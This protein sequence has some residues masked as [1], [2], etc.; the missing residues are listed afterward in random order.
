MRLKICKLGPIKTNCYIIMNEATGEAVI[1]DPA[2]EPPVDGFVPVAVLLTHGHFD[3][4]T[5]VNCLREKHGAKI[6]TSAIERELLADPELNGSTMF[7]RP[8]SEFAN[9]WIYGCETLSLAGFDI[10]AMPTPGH[11]SGGLCFYLEGEGLLFSGDTLFKGGY[12]RY[13]FPTGDFG[14]LRESIVDKLFALP[15][16][17]AVYPG[18]GDKTT[19][20]LEKTGNAI[21]DLDLD[22]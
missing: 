18:H 14:A 16:A 11:T 21:L 4:V 12:G 10:I 22:R 15:D 8:I 2:D 17:T 1:V 7:S 13:D 9:N 20:A 5:G 6:Y 19:I 3:H